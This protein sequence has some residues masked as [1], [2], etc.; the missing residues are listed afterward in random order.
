LSA[1]VQKI[2]NTTT[3][4]NKVT[5]LSKMMDKK[6]SGEYLQTKLKIDEYKQM[7]SNNS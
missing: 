4:K 6:Y 2:L 1:D 7:V 5:C 3:F